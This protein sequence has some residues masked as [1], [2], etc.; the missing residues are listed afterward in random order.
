MLKIEIHLPEHVV[1][2]VLNSKKWDGI[3]KASVSWEESETRKGAISGLSKKLA[4]RRKIIESSSSDTDLDLSEARV[5]THWNG[6]RV[7]RESGDKE[8]SGRNCSVAVTKAVATSVRKLVGRFGQDESIRW[9]DVYFRTCEAGKHIWDGKN[10]AYK[11][12]SSFA[13]KLVASDKAGEALWW[14]EGSVPIEDPHPEM[15]QWAANQYAKFFLSKDVMEIKNPSKD[16]T[17][18]AGLVDKTLEF[19]EKYK[20]PLTPKK[21][22]I[23][24]M[25]CAEGM[26]NRSAATIYPDRL[27]RDSFWMIAMAQHM[28]GL[29]M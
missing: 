12:L 24:A 19:K 7:V 27:A 6:S 16:Y 14:M 1:R 5:V 28:K 15:T 18:F 9:M 26:R 10:H 25:H 8:S 17:A 23:E 13:N 2:R 3:L 20:T 22:I 11:N 4:N 29:L 21:V